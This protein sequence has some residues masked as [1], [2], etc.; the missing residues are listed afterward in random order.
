MASRSE[1]FKTPGLVRVAFTDGLFEAQKDDWGNLNFTATILIPKSDSLAVYEKAAVEASA[2]EWGGQEKAVKLIKDKIIH[3]PFLDGDGPQ[4]RSKKTGEPHAGFPGHWFLRVKSG[5][6]Y[7]PT[8]VDRKKIPIVSKGG[9]LYSGCYGYAV[10]HAFTWENDKKG[11]GLTFG[12]DMFQV[13]KDGERLGGGGGVDV[14]K[15]AEEIPD[16]GAAPESTK[17]GA[18]AG[19]LFG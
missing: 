7:P 19:G 4:G 18:G 16:E 11:K 9:A 2:A 13:A 14:D 3:S 10:L 6:A 15:W 17:S 8:L 1:Q 12:I 5:E